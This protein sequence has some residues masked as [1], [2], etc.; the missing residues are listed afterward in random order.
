MKDSET[1]RSKIKNFSPSLVYKNAFEAL[2]QAR[3][4]LDIRIKKESV[5][6]R[7]VTHELNSIGP[8]IN[9]GWTHPTN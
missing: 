8:E 6:L 7:K 9:L 2:K 1:Y 5:A 3:S 4:Q